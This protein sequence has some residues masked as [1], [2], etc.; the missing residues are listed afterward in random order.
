MRSLILHQVT[1][2]ELWEVAVVVEPEA[3]RLAAQRADE[4]DL[5]EIDDNLTA[6]AETVGGKAGR[7]ATSN[8][9]GSSTRR[10]MH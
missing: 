3:A 4:T 2:A 9:T 8:V 6:T 7:S 1:F 10:F 5:R